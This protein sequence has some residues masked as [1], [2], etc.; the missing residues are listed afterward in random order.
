MAEEIINEMTNETDYIQAIKDLKE[1][2]VSRDAFMKLKEENKRL[3][4]SLVEGKG[5]DGKPQKEVVDIGQ[6]RNDLFNRDKV[7]TNLDHITASLKLR[8]ANLDAGK[9]D[10]YI[11]MGVRYAP[12][13][14]DKEAA[15][16]V[17]AELQKCVDYADGDPDV[18]NSE[19]Q[20]VLKDTPIIRRKK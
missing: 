16:R 4:S 19:L 5:E 7:R 17:A 12:T 10:D 14:S 13:S 3:I 11:P 8:Q 18:F 9:G 15:E 20:R 6:L 1:N 2:T